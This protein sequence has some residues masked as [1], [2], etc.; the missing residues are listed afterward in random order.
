MATDAYG[1]G[2]DKANIRLVVHFEAPVNFELYLGLR[3]FFCESLPVL[4]VYLCG[5]TCCQLQA[6]VVMGRNLALIRS[7]FGYIVFE[8]KMTKAF[9]HRRHLGLGQPPDL[10]GQGIS[11]TSAALAVMGSPHNASF[12]TAPWAANLTDTIKFGRKQTSNSVVSDLNKGGL[13]RDCVL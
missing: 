12:C 4:P 11:T 9:P 13:V 1:Q 6:L 3:S 8:P 2:I 5:F 7:C 10:G